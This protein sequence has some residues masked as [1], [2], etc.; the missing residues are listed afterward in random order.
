MYKSIITV[1]KFKKLHIL[2]FL[3]NMENDWNILRCSGRY[4]ISE[5]FYSLNIYTAA[6]VNFRSHVNIVRSTNNDEKMFSNY[7]KR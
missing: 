7:R 1:P 6:Y 5:V 3:I 2:S 4:F